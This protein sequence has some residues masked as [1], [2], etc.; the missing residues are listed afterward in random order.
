MLLVLLLLC[1]ASPSFSCISLLATFNNDDVAVA[2]VVVLR[3]DIR[4]LVITKPVQ[5]WSSSGS[6]ANDNNNKHDNEESA[7]AINIFMMGRFFPRA[8]FSVPMIIC[9]VRLDF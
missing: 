7:A 1:R 8:T 6:D 2:A 5:V 3:A 4:S 9:G